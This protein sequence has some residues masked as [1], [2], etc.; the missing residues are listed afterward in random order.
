M[1][2]AVVFY[3]LTGNTRFAA[4]E[5]AKRLHADLIEVRPENAFPDKGVRKFFRGGKSA[6]MKETP[7]L[8]P[9]AFEAEQYD[10]VVLAT[11][12]WAG[13]MSPPIRA[14]ITENLASLRDKALAALV[15]CG[16]G[17]TDKAFERIETLAGGH[18]L[19]AKAVLID[20]KARP[21]QDNEKRL[22]DFCRAL[23]G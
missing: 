2:A 14:F 5:A 16:G 17:K 19:K 13:T 18:A 9:Y 1:K 15:C 22:D 20:P 3:S 7:K 10:L 4:Q 12:V 8:L 11:P 21:D 23:K 6:V